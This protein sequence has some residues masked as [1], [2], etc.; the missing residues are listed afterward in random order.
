MDKAAIGVSR[1]GFFFWPKNCKG[2]SMGQFANDLIVKVENNGR[3][4]V[5]QEPFSFR[6]KDGKLVTVPYG[7]RTD[8]ASIPRAFWIL[9]PPTGRYS[10]AAVVHDYLCTGGKV[11]DNG[12]MHSVKWKEAADIFLD[13]ME[14]LKVRRI[15]RIPMYYAVR[16]YG[17]LARKDSKRSF[18]EVADAAADAANSY[19][20]YS[21]FDG[22]VSTIGDAADAV[23]EMLK[24]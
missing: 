13:A 10:K 20:T 7:Y 5:V 2:E 3:Y 18:T 19:A 17:F 15:A 9:L 1:R 4:S 11:S 12:V 22:V 24:D 8:F 6:T 16:V 21:M 23:G 14:T